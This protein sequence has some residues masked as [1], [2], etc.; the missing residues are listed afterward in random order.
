MSTGTNY[1]A[2][3]GQ[4]LRV[5]SQKEADQAQKEA[6]L[7]KKMTNKKKLTKTGKKE[8]N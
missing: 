3:K 2:S 8:Q 6:K 5:L 7:I 1:E 4:D